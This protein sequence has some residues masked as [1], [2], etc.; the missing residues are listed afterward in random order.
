MGQSKP[1]ETLSNKTFCWN[2]PALQRSSRQVAAVTKVVTKMAAEKDQPESLGFR[3][4]R[5]LGV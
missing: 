3:G 5:V 1:L 4:F 2:E